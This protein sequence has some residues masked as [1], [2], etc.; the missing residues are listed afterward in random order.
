MVQSP[1]AKSGTYDYAAAIERA[2]SRTLAI[3]VA[4]AMADKKAENVVVLEV[5]RL[6][7]I[8]HYFVVGTARNRRQAQAISDE[9]EVRCRAQGLKPYGLEGYRQASWILL[10]YQDVIAH[11]FVK[12]MRDYYDLE[13]HWGDAPRIDAGLPPEATAKEG[14]TDYEDSGAAWPV[15][16]DDE[17]E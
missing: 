8:T 15:V 11:V 2:G 4:R 16:N 1:A 17:S 12:E 7:G 14:R 6:I 3:D 9:I 13:L 10:D 5:A